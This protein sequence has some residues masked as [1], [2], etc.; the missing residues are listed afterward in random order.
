[1]GSYR[2]NDGPRIFYTGLYSDQDSAG[3]NPQFFVETRRLDANERAAYLAGW[4]P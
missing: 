3:L 4:R 1:V 2:S